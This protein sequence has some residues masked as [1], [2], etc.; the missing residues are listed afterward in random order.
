MVSAA[1]R[2]RLVNSAARIGLCAGA[3]GFLVLAAGAPLQNAAANG[4]TRALSFHHVHTGEDIT[5]TFKRDGR[6]DEAALAKLD[7]FMRDWRK[8]KSRH[9][10]PEL[11]DVLWEVYREV[12][13]SKPI[14]V[15]CGYR[16][17]TTNA[18]LRGRSKGSGVAE[19]SQ[20]TLGNAMDFYIPGVSLEKL[21]EVG[22][23]LEAGGVGFYP[24][25][26]SP[27]VHMD[28]GHIR[29]WPRMSYAQ[30]A[31][32]FPDGKTVH[33]AA[34]GRPLPHFAEAL[35][36]AE[37]RGKAPNRIM[38][39]QAAAHGAIT[40]HEVQTADLN[41]QEHRG[42]PTLLASLFGGAGREDV[43][44][45]LPA[46][47]PERIA[48]ADRPVPAQRIVRMP[49]V[50]PRIADT[51]VARAAGVPAHLT[52]LSAADALSTGGALVNKLLPFQVASAE[53]VQGALAYAYAPDDS[54]AVVRGVKWGADAAPAKTVAPREAVVPVEPATSV[55]AKGENVGHMTSGAQRGD[56]PWIRA[57]MLT[58]SVSEEL[59][60]TRFGDAHPE[61]Y[62][63]L[64]YKPAQAVAMRFSGEAPPQTARFTGSAVVFLATATFVRS[65]TASLAL[66]E[67]R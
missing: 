47:K 28:V 5:I 15:I 64:F 42:R 35:A 21:R 49:P 62:R 16:S 66:P 27:F 36:E 25:S 17:P 63:E 39:Q 46:A 54:F 59:T 58:P 55:V 22:L 48:A 38:L 53:P 52:A 12:G 57:A 51:A 10:D 65:Y 67:T 18:M 50:R 60:V 4:D 31:R 20:H 33:V 56:S 45:S 2:K 37:T 26:G 7:W 30:L 41:A 23:R 44:A 24:S 34:D 19:H 8:E 40:E 13:A 29:H 3:A 43:T 1:C 32:V 11:F 6:Y 61:A 9:M 14:E